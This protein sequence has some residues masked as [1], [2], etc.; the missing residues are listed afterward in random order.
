MKLDGGQLSTG[1]I[2]FLASSF[3]LGATLLKTPAVGAG[4][5]DWLAIFFGLTE[6]L[7]FVFIF[8]SL[9]INFPGKNLIEIN[10][11]IFGTLIGKLISF[12]YVFYFFILGTMTLRLFGDFFSGIIFPQ[13]PILV[14]IGL[15]ILVCASAVRNGIEVIA[16]CSQVLLPLTALTVIITFLLGLP[17]M[18]FNRFL[19]V[20]N[21]PLDVFLR[22]S[23]Y[24]AVFPF[25]ESIAFMML[26]AYLIPDQKTAKKGR[27]ALMLGLTIGAFFLALAA[28][29]NTGLL[30]DTKL[31]SNYTSYQAA[32]LIDIGEVLT[33]VEIIVSANF[34][35]MGF[36]VISLFYYCT[37]LGLAQVFNLRTYLP[38]VLP[39]GIILGIISIT[40]FESIVDYDYF[41]ESFT[42]YFAFPFQFL[43]PVLSLL[44]CK[45]R[46][47]PKKGG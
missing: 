37:V 35:T 5:A 6:G 28:I 33:R 20:I 44:I 29:R 36:L 40:Q 2:V 9:S 46:G 23:H 16:R 17:N 26:L 18:Q 24:T 22:V 34:L 39:I 41:T 43:F 12:A 42:T 25:G 31:I 13:T 14:I 3:C 45:I 15:T 11:I 7:F 19:P 10:N 30:G 32:R 8:T 21:V 27:F 4:H 47:L 38:L 1:Q